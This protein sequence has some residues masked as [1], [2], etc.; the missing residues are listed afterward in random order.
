MLS[1]HDPGCATGTRAAGDAS[2]GTRRPSWW[3]PP[4]V[5]RQR[6]GTAESSTGSVVEEHGRRPMGTAG[7]ARPSPGTPVGGPPGNTS[8]KMTFTLLQLHLSGGVQ[9][10]STHRERLKATDGIVSTDC[11]LSSSTGLGMSAALPVHGRRVLIHPQEGILQQ[12]RAQQRRPTIG[13]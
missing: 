13:W 9:V 8:P 12:A 11:R 4:R 1:V 7:P 3:T 2:T 5:A 6:L 10:T